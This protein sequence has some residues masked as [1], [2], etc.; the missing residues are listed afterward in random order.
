MHRVANRLGFVVVRLALL[1][2]AASITLATTGCAR[3]KFVADYNQASFD[4]TLRLAKQVDLFYLRMLESDARPYGP[5]A[6]Q[7]VTIEAELAGLVRREKA[8]PLNSE[9][10]RIAQVILG[11]WRSYKAKHKAADAYVDARFDRRRFE[12]LFEAAVSAEAAKRLGATDTSAPPDTASI[13][14]Q[15]PSKRDRGTPVI[16]TPPVP[17]R[18]LSSSTDRVSPSIATA[19]A[20]HAH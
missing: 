10:A 8:R 9:S 5:L 12:R 15:F 19:S 2:A 20:A 7:Y 4:E 16:I 17:P 3:V 13:A 11:F 14:Q 1:G 6:E 18:V